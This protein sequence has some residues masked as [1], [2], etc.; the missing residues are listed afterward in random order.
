MPSVYSFPSAVLSHTGLQDLFMTPVAA[1]RNHEK[2]T[3]DEHG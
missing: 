3:T 1:P 2:L